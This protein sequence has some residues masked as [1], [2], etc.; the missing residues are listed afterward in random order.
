MV[1]HAEGSSAGK[2][3][4]LRPDLFAHA[5]LG[6][7]RDARSGQFPLV[8]EPLSGQ[9]L[10]VSLDDYVLFTKAVEDFWVRLKVDL[11]RTFA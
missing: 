2:L 7:G 9:G 10:Y 5:W 8:R 3:Q 6:I 1:K 11:D 4:L